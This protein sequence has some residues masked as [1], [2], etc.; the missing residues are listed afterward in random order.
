MTR[1]LG[2]LNNW[3]KVELSQVICQALH[4][5]EKPFPFNH[6]KVIRMARRSKATLVKHCERA[7]E[8]LSQRSS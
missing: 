7:I 1:N 2:D 3:T 4:G 6:F 5:T 8:V